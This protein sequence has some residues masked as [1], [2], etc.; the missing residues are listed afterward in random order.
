M[1]GV[2]EDKNRLRD[3]QGSQLYEEDDYDVEE[4]RHQYR[5][6]TCQPH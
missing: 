4:V 2:A 1:A 5:C 6:G 3:E